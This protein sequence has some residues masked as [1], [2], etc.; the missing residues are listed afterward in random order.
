MPLSNAMEIL[1]FSKWAVMLQ[2]GLLSLSM[3]PAEVNTSP[4]L[5]L[6]IH[7]CGRIVP[8]PLW[9]LQV[10]PLLLMLSPTLLLALV[11]VI[12]SASNLQPVALKTPP[13]LQQHLDG[14]FP[15]HVPLLHKTN[16][17]VKMNTWPT[18]STGTRNLSTTTLPI[19]TCTNLDKLNSVA[20]SIH[21]RKTQVL[22][23]YWG[24]RSHWP[25]WA[26]SRHCWCY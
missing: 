3:P 17:L 15:F 9:L 14:L 26:I 7:F 18:I 21:T 6:P 10:V 11:A 20:E 1:N 24:H 4:W 25:C 16:Q 13:A 5:T 2:M 8:L 12:P 22:S 23:H 19:T